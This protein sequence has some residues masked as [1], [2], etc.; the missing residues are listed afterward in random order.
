MDKASGRRSS[1]LKSIRA[2]SPS[3]IAQEDW[4]ETETAF[5]VIIKTEDK[6]AVNLDVYALI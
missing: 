2:Y 6:I 1:K 3:I 4:L 5:L